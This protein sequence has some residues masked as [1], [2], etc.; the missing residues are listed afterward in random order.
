MHASDKKIL[1]FF[2]EANII[3]T[4]LFFQVNL[5]NIL[6]PNYNISPT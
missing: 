6:K 5:P 2:M 1:D 4:L 3:T